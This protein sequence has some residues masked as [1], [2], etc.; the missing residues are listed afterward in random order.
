LPFHCACDDG[1]KS[2][3]RTAIN[4]VSKL[5]STMCRSYPTDSTCV[6]VIT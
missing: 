3:R 5:L 4:E 6:C 2:E 1:R